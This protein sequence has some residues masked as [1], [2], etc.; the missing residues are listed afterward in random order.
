MEFMLDFSVLIQYIS[1]QRKQKDHTLTVEGNRNGKKN[2][3][4]KGDKEGEVR[5]QMRNKMI[6]R[7]KNLHAASAGLELVQLIYSAWRK[8]CMKEQVVNLRKT[9]DVPEFDK[10]RIYE[11]SKRTVTL[12][13]NRVNVKVAG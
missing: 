11:T 6:N 10:W 13:G 5:R 3:E 4:S 12:G 1:P 8:F 9:L 7:P 2:E